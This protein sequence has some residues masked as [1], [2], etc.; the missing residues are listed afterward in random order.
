MGRCGVDASGLGYGSVMNTVMN[1]G[2]PSE[3][4]N[5]FD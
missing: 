2:V 5:F 1:L 4:G 3:A